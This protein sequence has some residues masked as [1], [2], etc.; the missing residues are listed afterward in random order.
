VHT[1]RQLLG[2]RPAPE[3]EQW[4]EERGLWA[5]GDLQEPGPLTMTEMVRALGAAP[6][7]MAR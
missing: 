6:V 3:F 5:D 1:V 2:L 4:M 7:A